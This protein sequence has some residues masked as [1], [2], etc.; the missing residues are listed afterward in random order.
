MPEPSP[1]PELFIV[2]NPG[3]GSQ[4][5]QEV[6]DAIGQALKAAGRKHRFMPIE[7]G[8]VRAT[9]R[10][11]ARLARESGGA[12]ICAGGDGTVSAA[13]QAALAH[14]CVFGVIAQG[15]F[16]MFARDHGLPLDIAEAVR[17]LLEGEPQPV[18]VGSVNQQPFLVNASVGLYAK[19]LADREEV[20]E[21]FGRK[22]WVAFLAALKTLLAWRQ[23]LSLDAELDGKIRRIVTAS[24]FICNNR[25]QLER[26]GIDAAVVD[27]VGRGHLAG[28]VSRPLSTGAKLRLFLHALIGRL[29]DAPEIDAFTVKSLTVSNRHARRLRVALDGE[30]RWMELP[31]RIAV[32]PRPLRL[33]MRRL[34]EAGGQDDVC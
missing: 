5:K 25:M 30:V 10:E 19:L 20:K 9:C 31:L 17:W 7:H 22:R 11:A 6:R 3:S 34:A 1:A 23:K 4:D 14:D 26:V 12:L 27:A 33:L 13:A 24:L 28:I 16:N 15:T 32:G 29:R 18:Q 21:R 8:D 2:F